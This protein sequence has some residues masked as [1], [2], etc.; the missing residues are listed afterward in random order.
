MTLGLRAAM[1]QTPSP[2]QEWQYSGGVILERLFQTDVPQWRHVL[3]L[4]TELEP[5]YSGARAYK[6]QV[7]PAVDFFYKDVAFISTGDGVGYNFLHTSH[8]QAGVALTYDLGRR[9]EQDYTNLRGMGNVTLAPVAKVYLS[10]ALSRKLPLVLRIDARQFMGGAQ[11]A[12]GD[13]AIYTPLP[14][15][16][17][18]FVMFAGPS[19]TLA[20][21]H[22]LQVLYGVNAQQAV[23][24]GH[25]VYEFQHSGTVAAG[26]GFSATYSF[27]ENWLLNFEGA[28]SQFRGHT[29]NSPILENVDQRLATLSFDY[30]W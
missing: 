15:S 19:V 1:A 5:A 7:G 27:T 25:P 26:I 18:K 23:A 2:M 9:E 8:A 20:T 4:A 30:K 12:V 3:G 17:R 16:S 6:A 11:G 28:Y 29:T 10:W 22:Y 13:I 21:R 14:G 24:S